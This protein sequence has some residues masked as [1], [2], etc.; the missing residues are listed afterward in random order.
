MSLPAKA[1]AVLTVI[2]RAAT[3]PQVDIEKMERLL[4][5]QER[6]FSHQAENAFNDAMIKCQQEIPT[7]ETDRDNK[8]TNSRYATLPKLLGVVK[9]IYTGHGFS[10]SFGTDTSP[11]EGY[12]RVVCDVCHNAGH[13]KQY[14]YD[15]PPDA[16]G[17]KGTVN[18]TA[19][20]ASAS[21]LSY[22]QRYLIKLI[23]N[24]TV[25]DE[26]DDGNAAGGDTRSAMEIKQEFLDYM[27][28]VREHWPSIAVIKESIATSNYEYGV[29]AVA[30]LTDEVKKTLWKAPTKGGIFTTQERAV[31][32]SDEWHQA[33]EAYYGR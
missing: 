27:A 13:T 26:D 18:K 23:F 1:D 29:E 31:M 11:L 8:Q 21:A 33:R 16:T 32:K 2:E 5:M 10:L 6:I 20:H 30:E 15:L 9:P 28:A 17:I 4:A 3:D 7:I 12:I 24:I 25:M 22:G 14:F 19:V